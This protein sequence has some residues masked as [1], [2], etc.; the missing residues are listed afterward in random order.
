MDM[1]HYSMTSFGE[2]LALPMPGIYPC[3]TW[4]L[5]VTL[6]QASGMGKMVSVI[7]EPSDHIEIAR[8]SHELAI[9]HPMVP[10]LEHHCAEALRSLGYLS[11]LTKGI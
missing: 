8:A 7:R 3:L 2:Q 11:G 1:K 6:H 9:W 5:N 4:Q 10:G